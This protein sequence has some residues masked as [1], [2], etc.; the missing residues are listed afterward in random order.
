MTRIVPGESLSWLSGF[1]IRRRIPLLIAAIALTALAFFPARRLQFDYSIESLYS[2][3]NPRLQDYTE[4]KLLF[5]GDEFVIVAYADPELFS[6]AGQD[7]LNRLANRLAGVAGVERNSIQSVASLLALSLPFIPLQREK[8]LE[9]GRSILLGRDDQTTAVVLRLV[10]ERRAPV[11]RTESISTIRRIAAEHPLPAYVVGEPVLVHDMFRY[12]EDD[13]ER[14]GWASSA[15]L[16]VVILFFLR[17][18]RWVVLPIVVVQM[19]ILWTKAALVL[20]HLQLSMVSSI[21]SSLVTIIGVSTIVYMALFYR[22]V[23]ERLDRAA[24]LRETL[25]VLSVDVFW[26]CCTTAA[27]F[28]AQLSSHIYPVQSFGAMMMLGSMLVLV[29]MALVLPGGILLGREAAIASGAR[30]ETEVNRSLYALTDWVVRHSWGIAILCLGLL[31]FGAAGLFQLRLETDFTKNFRASSP[32]VQALNFVESRLG[33]AGVWEVNFPAP[34]VLTEKYLE[35]VQKLAEQLRSLKLGGESPLSKVLAIT[36]GIDLVPRIPFVVPNL[37][38]KLFVLKGL[39]PEFVPS[40]YDARA[41]RMRIMLRASERQPSEEKERLIATVEEIARREFPEAKTTGLYVL[42]SFLIE[43]LLHDQRTDILLGALGIL[44]IITIAY[45]SL[46]LGCIAL[47][48]NLLPILLVVGGM[49]WVGLPINIGTA[50]ISSDAMGLTVHDSIF[51]LS[52]FLRAR[53]AGQDFNGAL[54]QTQTEVGLPL[55]YSN[56]ALILGF[57][58]LTVS[59]FIPLVYFGLLVS[60]AILGGLAGNLVLLP[61]L[62]RIGMRSRESR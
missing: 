44:A 20:G 56:V 35:R 43:S 37:D 8:L 40:L 19:T 47:I 34:P 42:L 59:H 13:G 32:V 2:S 25:D 18:L 26:V 21:L 54:R 51:Y 29:T 6:A 60:V 39:Q 30:A 27:G 52:A 12:A 24:A 23:R 33:G 15:L 50:M 41:G 53:Q 11:P 57:L 4:S 62:L 3:Q 10:D 55:V 9:F 7:R 22:K 31:G 49:G 38:A 17:S 14:M 28:A 61:I 36:D 16:I 58:V 46:W 48:P 1:L 45:R 5:G